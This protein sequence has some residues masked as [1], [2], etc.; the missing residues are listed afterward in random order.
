MARLVAPTGSV[1]S[2]LGDERSLWSVFSGQIVGLVYKDLA[3]VVRNRISF[4][5][6]VLLPAV[7]VIG[8]YATVQGA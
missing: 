6:L 4:L 1:R 5:T 3:M 8:L 7:F 2:A